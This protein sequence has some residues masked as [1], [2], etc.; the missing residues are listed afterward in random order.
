MVIDRGP[1]DVGNP[2]AREDGR[3]YVPVTIIRES[4]STLSN[5]VLHVSSDAFE[6]LEDTKEFAEQLVTLYNREG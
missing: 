4:R 6:N 1:L 5:V 2:V 3:Y